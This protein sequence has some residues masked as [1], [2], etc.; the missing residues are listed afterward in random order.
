MLVEVSQRTWMASH[1]RGL[2]GWDGYIAGTFAGVTFAL[3]IVTH[4]DPHARRG[5]NGA[6]KPGVLLLHMRVC[7]QK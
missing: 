5:E 4:T 1:Y 2:R 7:H 3:D 6:E